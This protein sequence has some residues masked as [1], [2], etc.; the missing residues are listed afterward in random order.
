MVAS[1]A[2]CEVDP[3][4]CRPPPLDLGRPSSAANPCADFGAVPIGGCA[5]AYGIRHTAYGE[6][7]PAQGWPPRAD[8][9]HTTRS[10]RPPLWR[11]CAPAA[12]FQRQRLDA[13]DRRTRTPPPPRGAQLRNEPTRWAL[14]GPPRV[15][16]AATRAMP[17]RVDG[18][19]CGQRASA[20]PAAGPRGGGR[21]LGCGRRRACGSRSSPRI[22]AWH[23]PWPAP[24]TA[25]GLS[26]AR[27][28]RPQ[29]ATLHRP[30]YCGRRRRCTGA[31]TANPRAARRYGGG[32]GGA[33]R[34]RLRCRCCRRR[35]PRRPSAWQRER[36]MD[37][38]A[39]GRES[40]G[41]A[42]SARAGL[43]RMV[44]SAEQKA[45]T[46]RKHWGC[47]LFISSHS[48]AACVRLLLPDFG[49]RG[50]THL[51]NLWCQQ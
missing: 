1:L 16:E 3:P 25:D 21:C 41:R 6:R 15:P 49:G 39:R 42:A 12:R 35:R 24:P 47:A 51:K 40:R 5:T 45:V 29:V 10:V 30:C 36:A 20:G 44:I 22:P 4:R 8:C 31:S 48:L 28:D 34:W 7:G 37:A 11:S 18:G 32:G 46:F 33:P 17:A 14:A 2:R 43:R 9:R 50:H 27:R 38:R 26:G 19:G 23:W 13:A